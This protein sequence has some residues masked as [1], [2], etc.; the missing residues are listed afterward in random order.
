ME[1]DKEMKI[2]TE[3][4]KVFMRSL[5]V[6]LGLIEDRGMYLDGI[7]VEVGDRLLITSSKDDNDVWEMKQDAWTRG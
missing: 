7:R 2:T 6:Y 4:Y 1:T 3:G 5:L